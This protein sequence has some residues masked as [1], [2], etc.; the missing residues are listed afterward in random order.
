M[1]SLHSSAQ[2]YT[3]HASFP[4]PMCVPCRPR[5]VSS[6]FRR[7]LLRD[8][9]GG[10][11]EY[12]HC[13]NML[14]FTPITE[15]LLQRDFVEQEWPVLETAFVNRTP[16]APPPPPPCVDIS[17]DLLS[18]VV[19]LPGCVF[20]VVRVFSAKLLRHIRSEQEKIHPEIRLLSFG[21]GH[22]VGFCPSARDWV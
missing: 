13:I 12:V 4:V 19:G 3:R 8:R 18:P 16:G 7:T 5:T 1:K 11:V 6:L 21:R 9:F 22:Q 15:E 14:P 2:T 10:N 17:F 20:K